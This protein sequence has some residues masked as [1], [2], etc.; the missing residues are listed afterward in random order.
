MRIDPLKGIK[1]AAGN[2]FN[3]TLGRL[4]GAGLNKGA[5]SPLTASGSAS[6]RV[7]SDQTDWRVKLTIPIDSD[8][9][10]LFFNDNNILSPLKAENGVVF[11]LT[12]SVIVQHQAG[13]NPLTMPHSNHPHYA[14]QSSES[15]ALT[16]VGEFPVQNSEDA[17]AWV[18]TLHFF[19]AVTKMFFGGNDFRGNPPPI[20][21]LNGYGN[22]VFKNVP[23]VVTNFTV[24]LTQG[25]DYISTQGGSSEPNTIFGMEK[26]K[27]D[28]IN[29][30]I[31][32]DQ[33]TRD[34][35]ENNFSDKKQSGSV[36]TSWA[37]T[38]SIFTV[39]IQ[40]VYSRD[41]VKKFSMRE[42]VKGNLNNRDGI[43]F[44]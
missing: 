21:H 3:R 35:F 8:L 4:F 38:S 26:E 19:R 25:V 43:G 40:P 29:D 5:E 9:T 12:P 6:W 10:S 41:S 39:Q 14:Y 18:A 37:P 20:L 13:Y 23:V 33:E 28:F 1:K 16:I 24:E 2:V 31:G 7:R 44:I 15:S 36:S 42:F 11:P 22:Y 17:Q 32:I 30:L 34:Y 27:F